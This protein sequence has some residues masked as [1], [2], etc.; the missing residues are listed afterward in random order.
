MATKSEEKEKEKADEEPKKTKAPLSQSKIVKVLIGVAIVVVILAVVFGAT[1]L[2][3]RV[4]LMGETMTEPGPGLERDQLIDPPFT[5]DMGKFTV[6]IFDE[7]QRSYN[8]RVHILLTVNQGRPDAGRV[9]N[10]LVER[11]AQLTDAIYEVL[12]GMD[13]KNFMGSPTQRSEGLAE[14]RASIIR[15]V[16]SRMRNKIDGC[17]LQ[18]FIFQ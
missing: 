3:T 16:N 9:T 12:I 8:L 5:V 13:P 6:I 10:E 17:F 1:H 4:I 2:F 7:T 11:R 15:A 18:E 14:L